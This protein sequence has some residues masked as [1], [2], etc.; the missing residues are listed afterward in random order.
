M[1]EPQYSHYKDMPRESLGLMS[2]EVWHRDPKMLGIHLAR[3]KFVAKMLA[4]KNR[5]AE[6]GCGDGFYSRLVEREVKSLLLC[7]FDKEMKPKHAR[8]HDIVNDGILEGGAFDAVYSLDVMEHITHENEH[9]Y[10]LHI[11]ASLKQ[12]GVFI[13]GMPSLESQRYAS[14]A[15]RIGHVNCYSA[16]DLKKQLSMFYHNVFIFGMND[17]ALHTGFGPM[18]HYL[19]GVCCGVR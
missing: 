7:D 16:E 15:S 3:Y 5:V 10:L 19:V 17:E 6:V 2:N 18:C 4:G 12:E 13:V 14:A 9:A 11:A 8:Q 1:S